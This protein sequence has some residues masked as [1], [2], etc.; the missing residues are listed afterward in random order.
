VIWLWASAALMVAT[1]LTHS[2]LGEAKLIGP[3]LR[4]RQGV[5][6]NPF[7]RTITR[8]AWHVTSALMAATA[9]AVAWPGTPAALIGAIGAIWVALGLV[10]L[11]WTRGKHIG[12]PVLSAAGICALVGVV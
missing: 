9:L 10:S 8:Y 3:Q 11:V 2:I 12:W 7:A 6:A 1:A 5:M 4:A